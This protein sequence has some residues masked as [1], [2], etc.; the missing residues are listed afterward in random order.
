M[1]LDWTAVT[2][3]LQYDTTFLSPSFVMNIIVQQRDNRLTVC[4]SDQF[5]PW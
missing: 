3:Q 5:C 1:T 4:Y 2:K